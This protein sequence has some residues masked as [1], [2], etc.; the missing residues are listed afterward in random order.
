MNRRMLLSF[1]G[2]GAASAASGMSA[3][4]AAKALGAPGAAAMN[5]PLPEVVTGGQRAQSNA[6]GHPAVQS[7][8]MRKLYR[9]RGRLEHSNPHMPVHIATKQSWSPVFKESVHQREMA[10][11]DA[12]IEK[13]EADDAF[14]RKVAQLLGVEE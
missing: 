5:A 10:I 9:H 2:A 4:D 7:A 6:V 12:L 1:L 13:F 8:A 14:R 3:K 11:M